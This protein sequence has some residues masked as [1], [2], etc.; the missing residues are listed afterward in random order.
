MAAAAAGALAQNQTIG[1]FINEPGS[2]GGYT[3]FKALG[4]ADT[5]LIDS[6]GR[7]VHSWASGPGLTVELEDDGTLWLAWI[8]GGSPGFDFGGETGGVRQL[9][10][11]G[12]VLW[13]YSYSSPTYVAHHDIEVLPNGNVLILAWE[14]KST[15]E[16]VA[17]GRNPVL[18]AEGSLAPEHIVEV[19]PTGP[20]TG[21]IVWEWR[22]WDHLVQDFDSTKPNYG[23]VADHPELIDLNYIGPTRPANGE[24]DWHHANAVQYNEQL[25]QIVIS[26]RHFSEVWVI[27]HSTSTAEAAGH[28]GGDSGKGG[29]LLY[30]WGNPEAYG[31]G[32]A[33]DQQLFM[34]HDAR[35]IEPVLPGAGNILVFSNGNGRG[36][37]S[38]DEIVPP[39]DVDGNYTLASGLAYGPASPTWTYNGELSLFSNFISGAVRLP[40]GNTFIDFGQHGTFLEVTQVGDV[41]WRYVSPLNSA[42]P[43]LQGSN[44]AAQNNTVFRAYR[45]GADY[46][47]LTGQDLTPGAVLEIA[48]SDKDALSDAGEVFIHLT[49]PFD[50][51]TDA[52]GCWD[53]RE[54]GSNPATGGQ[55]SPLVFWDFFDVPAGATPA[56][57]R[58]VSGLDFFALLQRF[59]ASGDPG[60][61]PN[62][63]VPPPPAYHTAFDRGATAGPNAWNLTA[64]DGAIAGTDFL[65]LLAQFGHTCV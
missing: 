40:N 14:D 23:V 53:G 58:I 31:R 57:D 38:V 63:P 64:A 65:S 13:E 7:F 11:D 56:K 33:S 61:D 34:Q 30:R 10:W 16:A 62:S 43:L 41:V 2:Y 17:A 35:W 18:L 6:E 25:D 60:I 24:A 42:G 59:G 48:D 49:D 5:Y 15:S 29:D 32:D 21:T 45:Y 12:T 8:N 39:V 47:G 22:S 37:S 4:G 26:V 51:D 54:L 28:S 46:P 27:D 55:R 36:Y 44:P 20:T 1:L 52:D 19:Q 9:D 50:P 3:L